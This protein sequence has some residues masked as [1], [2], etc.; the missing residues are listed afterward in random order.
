[1]Q[2]LESVTRALNQVQLDAQRT[3]VRRNRSLVKLMYTIL[4]YVFLQGDRQ[5]MDAALQTV[6]GVV[7]TVPHPPP[8]RS[9]RQVPSLSQSSVESSD[10]QPG[11]SAVGVDHSPQGWGRDLGQ[12]APLAGTVETPLEGERGF[13]GSKNV[14][15]QR[16]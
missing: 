14:S 15:A 8:R 3:Q 7:P 2:E 13:G 11:P 10:S 4:I 9:S 6:M 5:R 16:G 12:V 1:M